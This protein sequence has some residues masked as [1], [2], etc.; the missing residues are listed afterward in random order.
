MSQHARTIR[1]ARLLICIGEYI[2]GAGQSRVVQS[3][4][5]ALSE[6]YEITLVAPLLTAEVPDGVR[7]VQISMLSL[8]GVLRLRRLVR[9]ADVVH[10]HDSLGYMAVATA[11]DRTK[12]LVTC[13]GIAPSAIRSGLWQKVKGDVTLLV[14]P[15][16]YRRAST[17]VTLSAFLGTWLLKRSVHN[18]VI[19]PN[20][21]PEEVVIPAA[22]PPGSRLIY[23]GEVS[24]RKGLDLLIEG[25]AACASEVTLDVVGSGDMRWLAELVV[26]W[27]LESRV[28]NHGYVPDV[29]MMAMIDGALAVVSFSKWEGFG[30]PVVEGFSRG[31]PAIV[32]GGSAMAELV[33]SAGAGVVVD[34]PSALPGAVRRVAEQWNLLSDA[35]IS[36]AKRLRWTDTWASYDRLFEG[37]VDGV[38]MNRRRFI[39]SRNHNPKCNPRRLFKSSLPGPETGPDQLEFPS[40]GGF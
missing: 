25:V 19:I 8:K 30:L 24:P 15:W 32:L 6:K 16:L 5:D 4:I 21:A 37:I 36:A 35:A 40:V 38:G 11:T 39:A 12:C 33:A 13:H 31:R 2:P 20:G 27:G 34:E 17:V 7:A 14:Y 1:R 28:T 3:E 26:R 23:I 9:S 10:L 29:A 22:P 18:H